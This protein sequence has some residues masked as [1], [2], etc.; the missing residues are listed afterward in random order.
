MARTH[1]E[2]GRA[3]R[4]LARLVMAED[5]GRP[6]TNIRLQDGSLGYTQSAINGAFLRYYQELYGP[7]RQLAEEVYE[8]YLSRLQLPRLQREESEMLGGP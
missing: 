5:R 3:R 1:D 2:E 8:G 7:Q 6:I 4:M